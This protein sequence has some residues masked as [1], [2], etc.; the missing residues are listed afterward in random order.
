MPIVGERSFVVTVSV[1]IP[2]YNCAEFLSQTLD[3]VLRQTYQDFEAIVIDD[4]SKDNTWEIICAYAD[5]DR[6]IRAFK[7]EAN[8][9]IAGNRN[10]GISLASGK[11]IAWQDADDISLPFRL[12]H[13]VSFMEKNESVG[14]VGGYLEIFRRDQTLGIRKYAESDSDLRRCIFRYSPVAQPAAMLRKSALDRVGPYDLRYPPAEDL[15][16]TFRIGRF[17]KLA[18][19]PEVLIRYRESDA[20]ATF[21]RLRKIE[22]ST[23]AIR[24]KNFGLSEYK[25]TA[26]DLLYNV[27]H[28]FSIWLIPTKIKIKIFNYFR[29]AGVE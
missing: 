4:C 11:Y 5:G 14:I 20:S 22:L 15:D 9:G 13:Q 6:R 25:V 27:A 8:L 16:M 1:I 12:E 3:S 7:N 24:W 28:F 18:N 19:L 26:I 2:A 29:N 17:Y 23:L 21:T 10:R